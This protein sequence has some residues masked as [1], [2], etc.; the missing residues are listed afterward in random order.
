MKTFLKKATILS[1]Y[2][3]QQGQK[4][5][6]GEVINGIVIKDETN[7]FPPETRVVTSIIKSQS[8]FEFIYYKKW[9]L[10]CNRN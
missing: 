3:F 8:N 2:D 6:L 10:L 4:K 9:K 1:I 5:L 7:R